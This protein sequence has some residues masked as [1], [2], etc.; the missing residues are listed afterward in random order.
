MMKRRRT[1]RLGKLVSKRK[2]R[3]VTENG[4]TEDG[5]ISVYMD[6]HG[7]FS[8]E[9]PEYLHELNGGRNYGDNYYLREEKLVDLIKRYED[10]CQDYFGLIKNRRKV[11]GYLFT[12][13]SNTKELPEDTDS[14]FDTLP[15]CRT[16]DSKRELEFDYYVGI[17][18]KTEDGQAVY[19]FLDGEG[20]EQR[21]ES[22]GRKD[23]RHMDWTAERESFF[24]RMAG[25]FDTL[26][27]NLF[28]FFEKERDV[29]K[30]IDSGQKLL[31]SGEKGRDQ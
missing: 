29:V 31:V 3:T 23:Y 20:K 5:L 13:R 1:H 18:Y 9:I 22:W 10:L 28:K 14:S 12:A 4:H 2:L 7:W 16:D 27:L 25:S 26:I 21:I 8:I 30:A 17:E 19:R 15:V 24:K 11:I 6:R